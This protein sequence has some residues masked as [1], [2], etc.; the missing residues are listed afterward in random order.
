MQLA[1]AT[2]ISLAPP[3]PVTNGVNIHTSASSPNFHPDGRRVRPTSVPDAPASMILDRDPGPTGSNSLLV[4]A[5]PAITKTGA[6]EE[7]VKEE[8]V[9]TANDGKGTRLNQ[10]QCGLFCDNEGN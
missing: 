2:N 3:E 10:F 7:T 5:V 4:P 6:V 1:P 9:R 8:F